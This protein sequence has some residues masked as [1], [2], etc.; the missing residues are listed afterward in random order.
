MKDRLKIAVYR[1]GFDKVP[2]E[3][4]VNWL[5]D[6][7]NLPVKCIQLY[8]KGEP[9]LRMGGMYHITLLEKTLKE[10]GMEIPEGPMPFDPKEKG[11][12]MVGE[13]YEMVGAGRIQYGDETLVSFFGSSHHY[14]ND[15]RVL[16]TN[17]EHLEKL[18]LEMF[19]EYKDR[20]LPW[21][22]MRLKQD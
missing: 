14:S 13:D 21:I 15:E 1:D 8:I 3:F 22:F 12:L 9:F 4:D 17:K 18:G 19:E 6:Q 2:K 10:F 7:G 20:K 16:F 11:A 5:K